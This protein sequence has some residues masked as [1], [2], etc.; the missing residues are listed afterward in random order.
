MK[1]GMGAFNRFKHH[2]VRVGL[3]TALTAMVIALFY[4]PFSGAIANPI[5]QIGVSPT[6]PTIE[7][8]CGGEPVTIIGT[9]LA[10]VV[11]GSNE[12]DVIHAG[13]GDDTIFGF[14][15]DDVICGGG[16]ADAIA[17]GQGNDIIYGATDMSSNPTDGGDTIRGEAGDDQIFGNEGD[18]LLD[19]GPGSDL[20]DGGEGTD[21]CEDPD[22]DTEVADCEEVIIP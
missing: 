3:M 11:L 9:D 7:A 4:T 10:D 5:L 17:G 21:T 2:P 8:T 13:E 20:L 15:G 19:G 14:G 6:P 1:S 22:A 18:D 12:R 16:G